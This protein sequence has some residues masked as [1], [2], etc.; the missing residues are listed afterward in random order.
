MTFAPERIG[1]LAAA[2][3]VARVVVAGTQGSVPREVGAAMLVT[4]NACEGTIGGGALEFEAIARAR[5]ALAGGGDRVDRMPLGPA[6]GQCCGG[7]VTVLTEVWDAARLDG[8]EGVVARPLPGG[9]GEMPLAVARIVADARSRGVAP[10]PGIVAGWMVEPVMQASREIWV[11]GAGHVGRAIV[12]VLAPLPGVTIRWCDSDRARFPEAVPAAVEVLIAANPAE[13]VTIAPA[14]AEHLV[15]TYS[16]AL[17]LDLCHRILARPFR[18]LGLI[19]SAT[20]AARFRSRLAALGHGPGEIARMVCPIGDPGLGK[21]PQAIAVGVAAEVLRA[22]V[23]TRL[24]KE[25]SA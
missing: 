13:L 20:K 22:G 11:W 15:L 18:N 4:A 10:A 6:L 8:I 1:E 14:H 16:H 5:G 3:P 23:Q 19:G 17:D 25:H 9:P 2:G 7:S 12:A 24:Q 21:H